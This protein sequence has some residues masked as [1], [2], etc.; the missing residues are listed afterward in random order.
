MPFFSPIHR[1]RSAR[2]ASPHLPACPVWG[3]R[4]FAVDWA[5]G[6]T[7]RWRR[8]APVAI[9]ALV[10]GA[11]GCVETERIDPSTDFRLYEMA[12]ARRQDRPGGVRYLSDQETSLQ[13]YGG[14]EAQGFPPGD[15]SVGPV[16]P[17]SSTPYRFED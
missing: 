17:A 1:K 9:L 5:I 2:G 10:A 3:S 4:C 13:P 8:V 15:Y 7:R 16:G 14:F 6:L 12:P 11:T